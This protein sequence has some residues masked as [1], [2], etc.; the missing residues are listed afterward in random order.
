MCDH[1]GLNGMTNWKLSRKQK[2]KHNSILHH[3][4]IYYLLY[5]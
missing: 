2:S 4:F 5:F 3:T 1:C